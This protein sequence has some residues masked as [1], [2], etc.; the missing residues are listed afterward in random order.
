MKRFNQLTVLTV[1][2]AFS[3]AG[4]KHSIAAQAPLQPETTNS[5]AITTTEPL[6]PKSTIWQNGI[7]E[8]FLPAVQDFSIE[9]GIALGIAAFGSRQAHDLALLSLAYGHML[10]QVMGEGHW[11]RGNFEGRL[12]LFGGAQFS[13]D[14]D[15]D[16]WLVGLT[17]HLRYNF[18]TGTRWIPFLDVGAGVTATGIGPPDLS[19]TF[20]FNL[21][22]S[23]GV[24]WFLRDDLA[25]TGEV[26]YMHLSCAGL[27]QPNLG[28]NNV[29]FFLGVTWFFGK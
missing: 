19:G 6:E 9:P 20:E 16:G 11:Y 28:I 10:G 3:V 4:T 26:R 7:G 14:V 8:G 21:Q 23:T 17:P 13:P 22:A 24:R 2:V 1:I 18:A 25:L 29:G 12:E 27:H 15:T 5:L